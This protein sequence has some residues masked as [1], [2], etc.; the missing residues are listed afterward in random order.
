MGCF[1]MGC[2]ALDFPFHDK[3]HDYLTELGKWESL[4]DLGKG[5]QNTDQN[6][7]ECRNHPNIFPVSR[8]F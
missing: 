1:S 8:L 6:I 2:F 4:Q 7:Q 5:L 3:N